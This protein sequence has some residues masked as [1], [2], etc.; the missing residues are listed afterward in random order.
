LRIIYYMFHGICHQVEERALAANGFRM[1]CCARCAGIYAGLFA[2][3]VVFMVRGRRRRGMPHKCFTGSTIAGVFLFAAD[4]AG[5]FL[6]V[7]DGGA[8]VRFSLGALAGLFIAPFL[9]LLFYSTF[10]Q[11]PGRPAPVAGAPSAALIFAAGLGA[12]AAN[13]APGAALLYV[14]SIAAGAGLVGLLAVAHFSILQLA[15][16]GR[17]PKTAAAV[18]AVTVT[19]QIA[20]FSYLR[21]LVGLLDP[22]Y[23]AAALR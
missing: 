1:P 21:S 3:M 16:A 22:E 18:A 14:E 5:N 17:R 9:A 13:R 6:G 12:F 19:A 4:A 8:A 20:L 23:L 2:G 10:E 15:F 7:W 11:G